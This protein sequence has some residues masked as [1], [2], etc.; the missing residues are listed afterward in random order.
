M[1]SEKSKV[2]TYHKARFLVDTVVNQKYSTTIKA[3]QE[4][5]VSGKAI[6]ESFKTGTLRIAG[7]KVPLISVEI[8]TVRKKTEYDITPFDP[9]TIKGI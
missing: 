7:Y 3:G 9:S 5:R 8:F 4:Y 1:K 2:Y 6:K